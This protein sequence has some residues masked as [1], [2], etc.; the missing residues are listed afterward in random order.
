[1]ISAPADMNECETRTAE[2][3]FV[4]DPPV[5]GIYS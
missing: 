4:A 3:F 5:S 2:I 1:M